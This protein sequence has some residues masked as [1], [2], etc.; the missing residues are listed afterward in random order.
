VSNLPRR[1]NTSVCATGNDERRCRGKSA[2]DRSE[3]RLEFS[4][5]SAQNRLLSPAEEIGAV[6][7]DIEPYSRSCSLLHSKSLGWWRIAMNAST[8]PAST[9]TH[10]RG[11]DGLRA[12]AVTFVVLFHL[13]PGALQGGYIGVDIFFVISGFLITSLLIDE[14]R[15]TGAIALRSFWARRARRLLPALAL[16]VLVSSSLALAIGGD[17][18]VSIGRQLLGAATFSYNWLAIAAGSSYFEAGTP[19]LFRNLWSLAVEEQFYL[20]WPLLVIALLAMTKRRWMTPPVIAIA[21]ASAAAMVALSF[22]GAEPTRL[23]YGTDTHAFGL[24]IGAAIAIV[25]VPAVTS[26]AA[27]VA[28]SATGLVAVAGL[29]AIALVLVDGSDLVFRGGLVVVA[30]LSGIAVATAA[31]PESWFG[32]ALDLQ[33]LRWV[34]QRS[35]GIY[36]WHWPAFVLLSAAMPGW[37]N[38]ELAVG[39]GGLALVGTLVAA[40][41]SY[42]FVEQPI[43]RFGYRAAVLQWASAW[44]GG[45]RRALTVGVATVAVGALLLGTVAAVVTAPRIGSV[46]A[47]IEQGEIEI[48][49]PDPPTT[50]ATDDAEASLPGGNEIYAVGDSVMLAAA[51]AVKKA[52]P[53]IKIDAKVSRHL[54]EAIPIIKKLASKGKLR[55]ILVLGLGTN[56]LVDDQKLNEVM[57]IVGPQTKVVLINAQAPRDWIPG[58]NKILARYAQS[59]RNVE[60]ANWHAAIRPHIDYL[61]TDLIHAGG[62]KGGKIYADTVRDAI[63]RLADLPPLLASNDFGLAPVPA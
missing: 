62:P 24:A 60:L 45:T 21:I 2:K 50:P 55:P 47:I 14:K 20:L 49:L 63:Q 37:T 59:H 19:E 18:L 35:Y 12:L 56:G 10:L 11:L 17:V 52:F 31:S 22:G 51:P 38:G 13:T 34:G 1:V 61:A 7:G 4:L 48:Q 57:H 15:R 36:L 39:L 54:S 25:G 46:Q 3:P 29:V 33:P 30:L 43:R 32:R 27:R 28:V 40:T 44:R 53:G 41:L 23:Y 42:R 9:M 16:L 26:R 8:S 6:I 58:V 5:H